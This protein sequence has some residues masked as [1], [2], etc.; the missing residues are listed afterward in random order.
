MKAGK[1]T[2]LAPQ[3]GCADDQPDSA[4][5]RVRA[6]RLAWAAAII[7]LAAALLWYNVFYQQSD[8][9]AASSEP[10]A[11]GTE[12]EDETGYAAGDKLADFSIE[13]TDGSTFTL[14]DTRGKV[15]IINLWATYCGP[16][17]A[18]LPYFDELAGRHAGDIAILAVHNSLSKDDIPAYLVQKG[19]DKNNLKFALDTKDKLVWNIVGGSASMPQTIV[20]D[21]NGKVI[22]NELGSVS[23]ELLEKL[24]QDAAGSNTGG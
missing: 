14:A 21:R 15:T 5:K 3:A 10:A 8:K 12:T 18:E 13:C 6:G 9:P 23:P 7:I 22:Y 11:T 17:V 24:Y 16:C 19:W 1:I 4:Q 20:L 2:L